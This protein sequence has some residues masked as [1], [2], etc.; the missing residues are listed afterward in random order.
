MQRGPHG[1]KA[2]LSITCLPGGVDRVWTSKPCSSNGSAE[3]LVAKTALASLTKDPSC[4]CLLEAV[5]TPRERTTRKKE[6]ETHSVRSPQQPSEVTS[7]APGSQVLSLVKAARGYTSTGVPRSVPPTMLP[8]ANGAA[9]GY[10]TGAE[11][12]PF[13]RE[14]AFRDQRWREA[15]ANYWRRVYMMY[16]SPW[17]RPVH[18][19]VSQQWG[20]PRPPQFQRYGGGFMP[21][22]SWQAPR[23]WPTWSSTRVWPKGGKGSHFQ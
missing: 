7:P 11:Y 18:Y 23:A 17:D 19:P 5:P 12:P 16:W 15:E 22:P 1:C 14:G 13:G 20:Y 9:W 4:K 21:R 10:N 2:T 8:N 6:Q 3:E